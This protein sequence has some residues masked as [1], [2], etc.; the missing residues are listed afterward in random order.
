MQLDTLLHASFKLLDDAVT[1]WSTLVDRLEELKKDAEDGLHQAANKAN[2]AGMNAQVSKE[3]IGKTAGEFADAHTQAKT[4]H[5]ILSDTRGELKRYHRQL[6]EAIDRGRKKSLKV[7]GYEGGFTVTSDVP[8][9]GRAKADSDNQADLTALRDEVQ[10]ILDKASQSDDS[11]STVLKAIAD[12]ST[13]GFSDA[14]YSDRDSA[15][16]A[17]KAAKEL[18][19]LAKKDPDDLTVKDFDRLND[20]LKKYA[21]DGLFGET[22]ATTLGPK[23]TLEFW[24]GVTDANRGNYE[25]GHKRLDQFDDLQRNLGLTLAHASQSDSVAMTEWKRQMIDISDKPIYGTSGGPMG[26]QV[27]SNLMR[28]GNY[29]DQFLH[30]YG[31]KLMDTERKFTGNGE[32]G[33]GA[34]KHMGGSPWLN[35][36]GEDSGS[37]PLTG[38]L[39]GLSNSPDAATDF[40]NQ[41]YISKDNPD[42]P[43]ERDSDDPNTYKGKVSLSNFQYLFEERDWPQEVNSKGDD[44]HT[45]QNNLALALEAAT[46]GHPA[47][48][49]PTLDTPP[50]NASQVK[51]MESIVASISDDP[52]RLTDNGYMSDSIGQI[53]SEYLPDINRATSGVERSDD[54][55]KWNEVENL[56]PIVGSEAR[57]DHI[58]V[59]N[60]LFTVGHNPEGYAAVEVGQKEYMG[61]LMDYHLNPDLPADLRVSDDSELVI[62]QIAERSGEISGTLRL[63]IQD[64]IGDAAS[65]KDKEYEQSVAQRKNWISGGV[66][67]AVGVGTSFVAT[68]WVGALVGGAAGTA[69]G[70]VLESVFQDAEG[71]AKET[72]AR[73]G[74]QVWQDGWDQHVAIAEDATRA[75][76]DQYKLDAGDLGA[77]ARESARQGYLNSRAILEG[78]V[79]GSTTDG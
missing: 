56:Y 15:A 54:S 45:G 25:L 26:F 62:R 67:T 47:G 3:F 33:N 20:G 68:P 58:D 2:W 13:L 48:E 46:T 12:Q 32:H 14:N 17:V 7:I 53:T 71:S 21:N 6:T 19:K 42:N 59:S 65:D 52:A 36:I 61:R 40:F 8:P 60:L 64:E 41:Q 10:G 35:R 70:V 75:A 79:P 18:A 63:G 78:Q 57:L 16:A 22:F 9:E 55:D 49:M 1:D 4:I 23:K 30:D 28:T 11:A 50:H 73:T 38:Y 72:A 66:G 69:T 44:L 31:T 27:M 77:S 24:T 39:K 29:D 51:L 76:A 74:G 37:D 5:S 43:F 34:W